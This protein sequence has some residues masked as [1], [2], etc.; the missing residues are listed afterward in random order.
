MRE[1]DTLHASVPRT[2]RRSQEF[3][4]TVGCPPGRATAKPEKAF[5]TTSQDAAVLGWEME[6]GRRL[7]AGI[8]KHCHVV[9]LTR[10][11][12]RHAEPPRSIYAQRHRAAGLG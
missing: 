6:L 2:T 9:G 10:V 1:V 7:P 3:N 11:A 5:S 4:L 8:G 12:D